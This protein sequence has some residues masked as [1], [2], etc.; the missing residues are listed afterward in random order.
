[1]AE[2]GRRPARKT[3][4]SH[5]DA[6]AAG[7]HADTVTLSAAPR[8]ATAAATAAAGSSGLALPD[9][10]ADIWSVLIPSERP[11][12][13]IYAGRRRRSRSAAATMAVSIEEACRS[14]ALPNPRH[15]G[16][17][18]ACRV[19]RLD[20]DPNSPDDI[21]AT[22]EANGAMRA[23]GTP[24]KSWKDCTADLIRFC[25][26]PKYRS[27]IGQPDRRSKACL[28]RPCFPGVQ[29]PRRLAPSSSPTRWASSAAPTAA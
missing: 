9:A 19:M 10:D 15:H 2:T 3:P 18:C 24:A 16:L 22:M 6:R 14:R 23:A 8:P 29:R 28:T 13:K 4:R 17:A 21:Y 12:A 25:E 20:V 5:R 1:M 11:A 26:E 27:R 7:R